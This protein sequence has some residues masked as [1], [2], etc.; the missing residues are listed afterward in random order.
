[1]QENSGQFFN[2]FGLSS[3]LLDEL[4]IELKDSFSAV[5]LNIES[6]V[7]TEERLAGTLR[8]VYSFIFPLLSLLMLYLN[9]MSENW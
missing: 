6:C 9:S 1:M 3:E 7:P 8:Y 2:C 5:D 4:F